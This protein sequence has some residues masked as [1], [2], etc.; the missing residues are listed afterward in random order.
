MGAQSGQF[1]QLHKF[2]GSSLADTACYQRLV[3]IIRSFSQPGDLIV[4]S[5]AGK[6]TNHLLAWTKYLEKDGRLAH[7]EILWLRQYHSQL[8]ESLFEKEEAHSLL[9]TFY[10]ELSEIVAL[11]DKGALS[12]SQKAW[13]I[14]HGESWSHRLVSAYLNK[15]EL[16]SVALDAREFLRTERAALPEVDRDKSRPL[17]EKQLENYGDKRIVI[18]G[19]IAQNEKGHTVLLGRNGSDYSATMIG[20][21][22]GVSQVTLWHEISGVF[23]ADPQ[24]VSN[25]CLLPLLRL[26]E[27][28][29][30]ARLA[31]PVLHSRTLQPVAS[32]AINLA[33]RS[34]HHPD[35]GSTHVARVLATGRGAKTITSLEDVC[36]INI[37]VRSD[38]NLE[39]VRDEIRT[40]LTKAQ[41]LPLTFEVQPDIG[42]KYA[43]TG[44]IAPSAFEFLQQQDLPV[45][46]SLQDGFSMIAAVGSGVG[47]NAM[48]T[49][50]FYYQLKSQPVE[51]I[52]N[53]DNAISL[54][55]V[56]R[57][58]LP[59]DLLE[60]M[61][62]Q[63]FQAQKRV[64][65]ILCGKGKIGSTWLN[66]FAQEQ[67]KLA[68]RHGMSFNLIGVVDKEH[69]LIDLDGLDPNKVLKN[70]SAE[71]QPFKDKSL[72]SYFTNHGYDETVIID[73]TGSPDF[74]A[75]YEQIA[76]LGYHLISANKI[77]GASESHIYNAVKDAF[78][79]T[80]RYWLSNATVGGGLPVNYAVRDLNMSGDTIH[81]LYGV[82]SGTLSWLFLLYD[83]SMPFIYL[84]EQAWQQ[85]LTESDPREDLTGK[86]VK[87]K[88]VILAREAGFD[89]EPD[90][91]CVESLI[92]EEYLDMDLDDFFD[93]A[94]KLNEQMEDRVR[95]AQEGQKVLRY[96][97]RLDK[98]GKA[99]VGLEAL[100]DN[101]A[102]AGLLP[103]DH[104][105][106]IKSNWYRDNPLVI[107][108]PGSGREMTAGAIQSDLNQ[109]AQRII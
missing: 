4:V 48:Q 97:A 42:L 65:I 106:A 83:G 28:S 53:G 85:G 107:R 101:H 35:S 78:Q 89:I 67:E 43:Y 92:P 45:D 12:A 39:Q 40:R 81:S 98:D 57:G 47:S 38:M 95:K 14:A 11:G 64:G 87:R 59:D 77:A 104:I 60:T 100:P 19:F 5:A 31:A 109:L 79:K 62:D 70:F 61:H 32:S 13:A 16:P 84:L 58:A 33:L 72:F 69:Y 2:G 68:Q 30:L 15:Y 91:V 94:E 76:E 17:L 44:E 96:I 71:A 88:L 24:V 34:C 21:L 80:G 22:A 66:L 75:E 82:F 36:V 52:S 27:A 26:D 3:N 73:V 51:F 49:H 1:R 8:I 103:C 90:A 41:L 50:G 20:A 37:K 55:A 9:E 102:L 7:D 29:E 25:A 6:T 105:F 23:S 46:V 10:S 56:L 108:G 63:L 99:S 86:D 18:P 54:I 93:Q 74:A